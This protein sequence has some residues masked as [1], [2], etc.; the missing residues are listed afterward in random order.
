V[1][2][3]AIRDEVREVEQGRVSAEESVLRHA[4]HTAEAIASDSWPHP[5]SRQRAAFPAAWVRE[6]KFWP[7]V[8]RIDNAW[9]D[10]HLACTCDAVEA[11]AES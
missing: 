8:G 9:G 1:G 4:P 3:I 7:A 10:R 2:L 5:Y 6:S 11:Y